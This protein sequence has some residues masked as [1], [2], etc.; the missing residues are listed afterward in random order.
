MSTKSIRGAVI[1]TDGKFRSTVAESLNGDGNAGIDVQFEVVVPFVKISHGHLE[2]L[3]YVD[4]EV[5]FLDLEENPD[6]GCKLATFLTESHPE[7]KLIATGGE[8]SPEFLMKAM[9]AGV[10][11]YL[12]KPVEP[13]ALAGA[14][15]RVRRKIGNGRGGE[16]RTP[17]ELLAF[18]AAKGGAGSTT[19]ATNLAI[20]IHRLTG[21]KTVVVDLDLELGEIALFLG[22]EPQ[23]NFVDLARNFH[24]M[25]A[26]LL[27]S[28]IECHASGVHVLSAPY[29]PEKAEAVKGDQIRQILQFLKR[30]YDYVV[31][32]TSNSFTPRTL[33]TFEQADEIFLV[34]NVDLP[35][36]RNIQR[37]QHLLDRMSQGGR[38]VKL[39]VNRH[40]PENDITLD[41]VEQALGLDVYWTLPN[42][43]EAVIYSINTGR[44]VLL[45]EKCA[46]SHE[47]QALGAKIAGLPG[48]VPQKRGWLS[49]SVDRVRTM[50]GL[51]EDE[52]EESLMLPP[53]YAGG[54]PV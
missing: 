52:S 7:R 54:E 6:L 5:I 15:G 50:L 25:D 39:I 49:R 46:Y 51:E 53:A 28:F 31:V 45:D 8:S 2:E 12:P 47:L 11:E 36:L 29:Q 35:S 27:A 37:C 41:D 18:F 42:D 16:G 4:P 40:Q 24:R 23:F 17:G 9:Q 13:E 3:R 21:K 30:H 10:S 32:D 34:A 20:Q 44:P 43:Y 22:V 14:I 38:D 33:A 1:S 19:V 26:G 48:A